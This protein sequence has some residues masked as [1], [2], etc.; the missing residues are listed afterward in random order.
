MNLLGRFRK[1]RKLLF[2]SPPTFFDSF[3]YRHKIS[4]KKV[5][6]G[7]RRKDWFL[8]QLA[9]RQDE[10][11]KDQIKSSLQISIFCLWGSTGWLSR[12]LQPSYVNKVSYQLLPF[13]FFLN[14]T[15]S[16][17]SANKTCAFFWRAH[18]DCSPFL[19]Q[20]ASPGDSCYTLWH[21]P[22]FRCAWPQRSA[23]KKEKRVDVWADTIQVAAMIVK[24]SSLPK[25]TLTLHEATNVKG[26]GKALKRKE[27][28]NFSI[29]ARARNT[30]ELSRFSHPTLPWSPATFP[31]LIH[32]N[33]RLYTNM[34]YTLSRRWH[35]QDSWRTTGCCT[36]FIQS[37]SWL[38]TSTDRKEVAEVLKRS[39]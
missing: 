18:F 30:S 16:R 5:G 12:S 4:L 3:Y 2:L 17:R 26:T 9:E 7:R 19:C 27:K 36:F 39:S 13:S 10:G 31:L 28:R 34:N 24:C 25:S 20:G 14:R 23:I 33:S 35:Y 11:D 32:D 37:I 22:V 21:S 29:S 15:S 8:P 38:S 1:E 6:G